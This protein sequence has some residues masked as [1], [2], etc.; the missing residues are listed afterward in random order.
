MSVW[1]LAYCNTI[2]ATNVIIIIKKK[3]PPAGNIKGLMFDD[4]DDSW[5]QSNDLRERLLR[6]TVTLCDENPSVCLSLDVAAFLLADWTDAAPPG[7]EQ[8]VGSRHNKCW[9]MI[10]RGA[11]LRPDYPK[12]DLDSVCVKETLEILLHREGQQYSLCMCTH[13]NIYSIQDSAS[14]DCF[15]FHCLWFFTC[16]YLLVY[17][18]PSMGV[19]LKKC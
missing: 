3:N 7:I 4:D 6:V 9:V 15:L 18:S 13:L 12:I 8:C 10:R 14:I 5:T 17:I 1:I 19:L 11:G 2:T 16:R